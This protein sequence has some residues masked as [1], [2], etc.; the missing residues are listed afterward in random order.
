MADIYNGR[1]AK[2]VK[3][4]H[5]N[6]SSAEGSFVGCASIC[7]ALTQLSNKVY[8]KSGDEVGVIDIV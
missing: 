4:P 8:I 5:A 3:N 7:I 6:Q 2:V 1:G